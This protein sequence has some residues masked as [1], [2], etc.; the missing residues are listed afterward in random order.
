[1]M[2]IDSIDD[3]RVFVVAAADL[4]TQVNVGSFKVMC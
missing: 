4:S 2:S 1:M 3:N